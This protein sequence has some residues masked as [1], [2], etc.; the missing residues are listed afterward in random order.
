MGVGYISSIVGNHEVVSDISLKS[1]LVL[2]RQMG[3]GIVHES[4]A[5]RDDAQRSDGLQLA[6]SCRAHQMMIEGRYYRKQCV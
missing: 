5:Q 3:A 1:K 6:N 4:R 2:R